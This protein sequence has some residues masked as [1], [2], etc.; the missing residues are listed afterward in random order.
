MNISIGVFVGSQSDL[1]RTMILAE[2]KINCHLSFLHY[3]HFVEFRK[4]IPT[5]LRI[6]SL[7]SF[8]SDKND[9]F[10]DY[11]KKLSEFKEYFKSFKPDTLDFMVTVHPN[12]FGKEFSSI[13]WTYPEIFSYKKKKMLRTPFDILRECGRITLDTSHLDSEWYS[14]ENIFRSLVANSDIVHLS[15][16]TSKSSESHHKPINIKGEIP[17]NLVIKALNQKP[18]KE[19]VLEYMPEYFKIAIKDYFSLFNVI[20]SLNK[21]D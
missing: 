15:Q 11:I 9:S 20:T 10:D 4:Y 12:H 5:N 17:M 13:K 6:T 18:V 14:S 21:L 1:E 19:L 3:D 2:K 16:R 7:H 8:N